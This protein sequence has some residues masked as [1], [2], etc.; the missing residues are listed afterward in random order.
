MAT[1]KF[2]FTTQYAGNYYSVIHNQENNFVNNSSFTADG[3]INN[4]SNFVFNLTNIGSNTYVA[5]VNSDNLISGVY[6]FR[7]Y[8]RN[9]T[10]PNISNDDLI[11]VGQTGWNKELGIQQDPNDII[12]TI[13]AYESRQDNIYRIDIILDSVQLGLRNGETGFARIDFDT[14]TNILRL[15]AFWYLKPNIIPNRISIRGPASLGQRTNSIFSFPI[16]A[17]AKNTNRNILLDTSTANLILSKAFYI[18]VD[19]STSTSGRIGGYPI[20]T[21]SAGSTPSGSVSFSVQPSYS[22]TGVSFRTL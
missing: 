11:S 19:T 2:N 22:P 16:T 14:V 17:N 21:P 3:P 7:V 1:L 20:Y 9:G 15:K 10:L 8:K 13:Q 4:I 12:K 6:T 18:T 5:T